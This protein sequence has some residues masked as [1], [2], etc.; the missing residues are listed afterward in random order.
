MEQPMSS[1][2]EEESTGLWGLIKSFFSN[3]GLKAKLII[4]A[5]VGIFSFIFI[6]MLQTRMNDREILEL[7]LE[8]VRAEIEIEMNQEKIVEN[9]HKL[10]ELQTRA[11]EIVKEIEEIDKPDSEREVSKEELDDFFDKRGF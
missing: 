8:K 9:N 2:K 11:E 4:G 6:K 1:D 10:E 3:I 7:E 5:I